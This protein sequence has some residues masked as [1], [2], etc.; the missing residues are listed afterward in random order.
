MANRKNL[1]GATNCEYCGKSTHRFR[2]TK[3]FCS[4]KCRLYEYR[5]RKRRERWNKQLKEADYVLSGKL[6]KEEENK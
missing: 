2:G 5:E 1:K 6:Y 3:R 4:D